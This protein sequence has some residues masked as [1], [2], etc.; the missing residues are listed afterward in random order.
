[1]KAYITVGDCSGIVCQGTNTAV[2]RNQRSGADL[3]EITVPI[4]KCLKVTES[5]RCYLHIRYS[6]V[7]HGVMA[8]RPRSGY[9]HWIAFLVCR[10]RSAAMGEWVL[11]TRIASSAA[12]RLLG[13]RPNLAAH[14]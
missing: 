4:H 10:R 8:G 7:T 2:I 12:V 13:P 11:L 14:M 3:S 5:G 9:I 1:M 6:R